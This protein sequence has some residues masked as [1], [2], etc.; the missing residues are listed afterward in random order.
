MQRS[1]HLYWYK[2]GPYYAVFFSELV[3]RK[4]QRSLAAFH[5][6]PLPFQEAAQ[7]GIKWFGAHSKT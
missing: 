7:I 3:R 2:F 6:G 1:I 4:H 5:E